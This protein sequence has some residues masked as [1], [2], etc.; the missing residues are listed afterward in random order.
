MEIC[1][2]KPRAC[3]LNLE[4]RS[5]ARAPP[6]IALNV[7]CLDV[8]TLSVV[9]GSMFAGS[10]SIVAGRWL[11][12]A[13]NGSWVV[14]RGSRFAIPTLRRHTIVAWNVVMQTFGRCGTSSMSLSQRFAV[15]DSVDTISARNVRCGD[16]RAVW[17][18]TSSATFSPCRSTRVVEGLAWERTAPPHGALLARI[19]GPGRRYTGVC[20]ELTP[21]SPLSRGVSRCRSARPHYRYLHNSCCNSG[22]VFVH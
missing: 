5:V 13:V 12:F 4:G 22:G 20:V 17:H 19:K 10:V 6:Y 9:S 11:R 16:V 14:V 1:G 3:T 18:M 8:Q 15:R 21:G 2:K 7:C